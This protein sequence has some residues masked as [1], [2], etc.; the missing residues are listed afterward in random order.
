MKIVRFNFS[1]FY[2]YFFIIIFLL[3]NLILN[4]TISF[5]AINYYSGPINATGSSGGLDH[6]Y[7]GIILNSNGTT[8]TTTSPTYSTTNIS[9]QLTAGNDASHRT[10]LGAIMSNHVCNGNYGDVVSSGSNWTINANVLS[11]NP[12]RYAGPQSQSGS[13]SYQGIR[14]DAGSG[15][16]Y[17]GWVKYNY[18]TDYDGG[19]PGYF[20]YALISIQEWAYEST[21]NQSITIGASGPI[22]PTVTTQAVSSIASTTATGNGNVT[23][24][25]SPNPTQHGHCWNTSTNPTT[26]NSN[27]TLGAKGS[28]GAFTS[29]LTGLTAGTL[30]YVRAYATNTQ[31][32]AY[33][34]NVSFWTVPNAPTSNAAS[35]IAETS[36]NANWSAAIGATGYYLDVSTASDFS[37]YATGYN[38]LDVGNVTSRSVT[39]LT[40]G[41][42]YYYRIRAYNTGGTSSNSGSQNLLTLPAA[43]T[44]AAANSITTTSFSANWGSVT[45]ATS[46]RLD[47]S[48]A[49]DFSSFVTGYNNLD[50]GNVTTYSVTGLTAGTTYY[51]RVRAINTTGTGSN[52]NT[53]TTYTLPSPPTAAAATNINTGSLTA[54]WGT[55]TGAT[56]YRLDFSTDAGFGSFVGS[57]NNLDVGN[58]T[59]Y[60]V[61]GLTTYT[62]YYYRVRAYNSSGTGANS[63]IISDTTLYNGPVFYVNDA[64]TANDSFTS[65]IGNDN[66][67]MGNQLYPF[68]TITQALLRAYSGCTIYVD[69][70][71]YAETV[72]ITNNWT[73]LIGADSATTIIDPAGDSTAT[74]LYGIYANGLAN[75]RIANL[76]I[77]DC[78]YGIYFNNSDTSV[79]ENIKIEYCGKNGGA[80]A[81]IYLASGS[82][83]NTISNCYVFK[84]YY[85]IYL[86]NSPYNILS[87]NSVISNPFYGIYAYNGSSFNYFSNNRSD[88]N[89]TGIYTY[90]NSD[91]NTFVSNSVNYTQGH[92]IRLDSNNGCNVLTNNISN[93]NNNHGISVNGSNNIASNNTANYN[94]WAGFNFSAS[95]NNIFETNTA[96]N[97]LQNGFQFS[98]ASNN[99]FKSNVSKSN[100]QTG[101]YLSNNSN[102]NYFTGNLIIG[103]NEKGFYL[104]NV[105][106]N[107][108]T[109]NNIKNNTNYQIYLTNSSSGDTFT[110]NNIQTSITNPNYSVYNNVNNTFDFRYNYW[111]TTDSASISA[112]ISVISGS[113]LWSPFRTA[114]IDTAANADTVAPAAP[115]F[116]DAD[117]SVLKK[118]T[119]RW[120]KPAAD[121]DGTGLTGLTG[122]RIYRASA[123]QVRANGDTDNWEAFLIHTTENTQDTEYVDSGYTS[124]GIYYY[125]IVA[126]DSH[127]I[128]VAGGYR[129]ENRTWYSASFMVYALY[130]TKPETPIL[131]TPV[132]LPAPYTDFENYG[133]TLNLR[134]NLIWQCP[135]D[136][137]SNALHFLIYVDSGYG[138]VLLANSTT[139]TRGFYYYKSGSYDTFSAS[140]ADSTAYGNTVY[141]NPQVN[142]NDSVYRWTV[143][144]YDSDLYSDTSTSRYFKIGGRV[145]T[146]TQL[147]TGQS[148]IRKIHIDELRD[149]INFARKLRGLSAFSW[150]DPVI[151]ASQTL[152]RKTHID[153]LR[154]A[155]EQTATAAKAQTPVWTDSNI[156]SGETLIRKIHFDE[157]RQK[158]S[159]F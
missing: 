85:G 59:T 6:T 123:A 19:T 1:Y 96:S 118:V 10:Y 14:F 93:Y 3:L 144:A 128:P 37:S 23:A 159:D 99:I 87:G 95:S 130:N 65:N 86:N 151:T 12:T 81:G 97:N 35:S 29:S 8:S 156:T 15:N 146:D 105:S 152:I 135:A 121:E 91:T 142:L 18:Q 102:N 84:N 103:N 112:K 11:W 104:D 41:T 39:G 55:T 111:N 101:F 119:L 110:K 120:T 60:S 74:T 27:T 57:Y 21:L 26:A 124:T 25:G 114:E 5:G 153:E 79:I 154:S 2:N 116:I 7:I 13:N 72:V 70:G 34:S 145:W 33:G 139:D 47:V 40:A 138:N 125:R 88:S 54:N 52:S 56:G 147:T 148:L 136:A 82:C 48:I 155:E 131:L 80:G 122:Y 140:G 158:L 137:D 109:Q 51:Y 92:G 50:V 117:T 149:E 69:A 108:F 24:L 9:Q 20:T 100:S 126:F 143:V 32:T 4:S 22:V 67:N 49:S 157:L 77:F 115:S 134:P 38:N 113:V 98:N 42:T 66:L 61:T 30:Y 53:V 129:F 43:S 90:Q 68:R 44:A 62:V 127:Q 76:R 107:Y 75:L 28:T 83:S 94:T 31:G 78:Y 36:F 106:S 73:S 64:S 71:T 17:Y 150:T 16:Y 46:Y 45:S 133:R 132:N 89:N 58:V 141:F 63:N